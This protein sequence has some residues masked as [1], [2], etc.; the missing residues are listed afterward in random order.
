MQK[1]ITINHFDQVLTL[2][3]EVQL[4]PYV[5]NYATATKKKIK[6]KFDKFL[7]YRLGDDILKIL[8]VDDDHYINQGKFP[9]KEPEGIQSIYEGAI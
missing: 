1:E 5:R 8:F 9:F 2:P 4:T 3:K 7:Y 6:N